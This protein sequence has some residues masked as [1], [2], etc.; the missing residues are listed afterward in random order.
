MSRVWHVPVCCTQ[1]QGASRRIW[2]LFAPSEK[3]RTRA[4]LIF[5]VLV[6]TARLTHRTGSVE[7]EQLGR[8]ESEETCEKNPL[9]A[10]NDIVVDDHMPPSAEG[11]TKPPTSTTSTTKPANSTTNMG[12]QRGGPRTVPVQHQYYIEEERF[13]RERDVSLKSTFGVEN[14]EKPPDTESVTQVTTIER[15]PATRNAAFTGGMCTSAAG[16]V[17]HGVGCT[18]VPR[19]HANPAGSSKVSTTLG[20]EARRSVVL[21]CPADER[22]SAD[23]NDGRHQ[24]IPVL[25]DREGRNIPYCAAGLSGPSTTTMASH[26]QRKNTRSFGSNEEKTGQLAVEA[27]R[28][29][30]ER[31]RS[32]RRL[33]SLRDTEKLLAGVL[34]AVEG[35]G[36]LPAETSAS[37]RWKGVVSIWS[38]YTA[39]WFRGHFLRIFDARTR[40]CSGM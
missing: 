17:K 11:N 40:R 1:S 34:E 20:V 14:A 2:R 28:R 37:A 30:E 5:L 31:R 19:R 35:S 27:R 10:S 9:D 33:C 13:W 25:E 36:G 21:G 16:V 39:W 32:R 12:R 8:R 15:D 22:S 23:D 4:R 3:D 38:A 6:T 7:V 29:Q 24:T 18:R 26:P